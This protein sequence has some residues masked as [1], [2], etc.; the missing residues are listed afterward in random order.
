M[1]AFFH[2]ERGKALEDFDKTKT[3]DAVPI[4]IPI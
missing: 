3:K 1:K 2:Y 4:A